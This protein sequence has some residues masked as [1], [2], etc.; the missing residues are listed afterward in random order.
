VNGTP[1]EVGSGRLDL[2]AALRHLLPKDLQVVDPQIV[3]AVEL[4]A[5]PYTQTLRIENPSLNP[6]M[7]EA[8]LIDAPDWVQLVAATGGQ[9]TGSARYGEPSHLP[10]VIAPETLSAGNYSVRLQ[11]V[12][13]LGDGNQV[14]QNVQVNLTVGAQPERW[15]FPLI[16]EGIAR[17]QTGGFAWE[18]PVNPA[19]RTILALSNDT[20][21]LRI[22]LP[23]TF[24]LQESPYVNARVAAD[25]FV[26][27][28]DVDV[29]DNLTNACLPESAATPQAIYGWWADLDPDAAGGQVSTFQPSGD[30]FVIEFDQVSTTA[31]ITPTYTVSFQIVLYANGDIGLNYAQTP[32]LQTNPP[33]VTVGVEA[34]DGLFYN[35]IACK[36]STTELGYLP[37]SRQSFLLRAAE[38]VY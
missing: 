25:G 36:D 28:P 21:D 29:A 27:L 20:P 33:P 15:Y 7:W 3:D 37:A 12:G 19:D 24:T 16:V 5:A 32:D 13:N 38:G 22:T 18:T 35:Q 9:V 4:G 34:T 31:T 17:P 2:H 10:I 1:I 30:R 8:S 23:F 26:T 6:L 11:I 14:I